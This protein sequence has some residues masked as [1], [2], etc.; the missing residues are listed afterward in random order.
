L[1]RDTDA[2]ARKVL[3]TTG[4]K[5]LKFVVQQRFPAQIR[6]SPGDMPWHVSCTVSFILEEVCMGIE[7]SGNFKPLQIPASAIRK[8]EDMGEMAI[9]RQLYKEPPAEHEI[10]ADNHPSKTYA[11]IEKNGR[12][13]ATIYESGV[14]MTPNDV[15]TPPNLFNDGPNLAERRLQQMQEMI[16]GTIN[17][18]KPKGTAP[19]SG[20]SA[21][22]LFLAQLRNG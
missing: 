15:G 6:G 16:G 18:A 20:V 3:P 19:Q 8:A 5:S 22:T 13:M 1:L 9:V 12:V 17:Y 2:A 21:A 11:T 10:I 14:M 4:K 7:I